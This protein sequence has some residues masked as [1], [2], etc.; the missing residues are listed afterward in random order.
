LRIVEIIVKM[1]KKLIRNKKIKKI[2]FSKIVFDYLKDVSLGI[3]DLTVTLVIDPKAIIKKTSYSNHDIYYS[4]QMHYFRRSPY[5]EEKDNKIY[6]TP[7]GRVKIIKNILEEKLNKEAGWKGFWWAVAFDIPEKKR[8]ARDLLRR[9]LKAMHFIEVQKSIWVT[10]YDI[11]KELSILLKLW[12]KDL[13]D[14]IRIFK[15]EK[16]S[17][18]ADL[19]EYFK[20]A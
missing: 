14:N 10:P 1:Q 8:Q 6:V 11:E 20:I 15:I 12:L 2:G 5:F 4:E 17:D 13:G 9:E 16:I 3:L 18:D 19:R 7:K